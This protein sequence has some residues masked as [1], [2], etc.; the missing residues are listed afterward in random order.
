MTKRNLIIPAVIMGLVLILGLTFWYVS[1]NQTQKVLPNGQTEIVKLSSSPT[2][3]YNPSEIRVK[4]G[5]NV[6]IEGDIETLIGG[7]DTVVIKDYG[8]SKK[9]SQNDN[10][11]EF[12][13]DKPGEYEVRCANYMGNAKLIV[14]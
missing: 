1:S 4:A 10:V 3:Q 2:G 6:R 9:I 8:I 7:M 5:T 11:I 13:A 12:V 14:E